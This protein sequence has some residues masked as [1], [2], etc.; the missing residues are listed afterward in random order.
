MLLQ[1][2]K[3]LSWALQGKTKKQNKKMAVTIPP[4][5]KGQLFRV[6][7][8]QKAS[9]RSMPLACH[10]GLGGRSEAGS[11]HM[12]LRG[13]CLTHLLGMQLKRAHRTVL[14]SWQCCASFFFF[15]C[16]LFQSPRTEVFW[17]FFNFSKVFIYLRLAV[18]GL[19]C[20]AG[21]SLVAVR[22]LLVAVASLVW[23]V[24]LQ[25]SVVAVHGLSS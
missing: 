9:V 20:C 17:V 25:A 14:R 15:L 11:V 21:F 4:R 6:L 13:H 5:Q 16:N 12:D 24:G 8:P 18:L 23:S 3:S 7:L 1:W 22:G 10:T 19:C 2:P